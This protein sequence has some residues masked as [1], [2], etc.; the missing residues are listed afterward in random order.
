MNKKIYHLLPHLAVILA[1]AML[2][3]GCTT[4]KANL[5]GSINGTPIQVLAFWDSYRGHYN[6]FQIVNHRAPDKDEIAMIQRQTWNDAAKHVI[7]NDYFKKYGIRV[8]HQ[9]VIDT[10]KQSV[11][12]YILNSPKFKTNGEFDTRIYHQSLQ[13][14]T[15][16]NLQPLREDYQQYKIPI[17]KLQRHLIQDELLTS[18]KKKAITR[19][20]Q[21][22]ADVEW[23]IIDAKD[24]NPYV[25][26]DEIRDYYENNQEKYQLEPDYSVLWTVMDVT[27][28]KTDIRASSALADSIHADLST[29]SGVKEVLDKYMP[30]FPHLIY[31]NSGFIRNSDLDPQIYATLSELREGNFSKP[32]ADEGGYTIY[33]LEQRT[34]SMCSF[35][36]L[37]IPYV[38]SK[39]SIELELL[40]VQ[41]VATLASQ[42]GMEETAYE[43]DL[44]LR[45]SG[46]I[47]PGDT[48]I[49]DPR[50][51]EYVSSHLR[52]KKAGH[53]FEPIYSDVFR[54]WVL[55]E[56]NE[57]NPDNIKPLE[58][59]EDDIRAKLAGAKGREIALNL[60]KDILAGNQ[61]VPEHAE[62][63]IMEDMDRSTR[64]QGMSFEN[65]FYEMIRRHYND[66]PQR[67][68]QM[69]GLVFIPRVISVET[70]KKKDVSAEDIR[71]VFASNLP[72]DWFTEWMEE[73]L[74]D[75][76]VEIYID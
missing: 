43:M 26:E 60:A 9:E 24:I 32:V 19:I 28:T 21:S 37:R 39:T 72:D 2:I 33:Q 48:W 10:L 17:M 57:N 46:R 7:L 30:Q 8:T 31:K 35:N 55:L 50:I 49:D 54:G 20:L 68:Y 47:T 64:M 11:P 40:R 12:E 66:E 75:A 38:P 42:I 59:V 25:S 71:R 69:G 65:V 23:T 4:N 18:D 62:T 53:I 63:Y 1:A 41:R 56:L 73:K 70:D 5:A 51:V 22:T 34:K 76:D 44:Q 36:T 27:P 61:E 45:R 14:D 6:N 29:G 3:A 58:K 67:C 15:P 13:Y 52:G 16:E 74:A